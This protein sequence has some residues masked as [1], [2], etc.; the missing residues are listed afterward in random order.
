V[1]EI[2]AAGFG[3]INDGIDPAVMVDQSLAG[4]R[5]AWPGG[6]HLRRPDL[7]VEGAEAMTNLR[8]YGHGRTSAIPAHVVPRACRL[9][10]S[11]GRERASQV[12]NLFTGYS[13]SGL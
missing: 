7:H 3:A 8:D 11:L 9:C 2:D 4:T 5:T 1:P 10:F 6:Y 12:E 13:T